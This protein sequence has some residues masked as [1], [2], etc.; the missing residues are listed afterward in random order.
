MV[1]GFKLGQN[2]KEREIQTE[3]QR[4]LCT[5]SWYILGQDNY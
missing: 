3:K 1:G 5:C 2:E 4:D